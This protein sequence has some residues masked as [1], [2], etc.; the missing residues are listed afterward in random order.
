MHQI[1]FRDVVNGW[2]NA[3]PIGNGRMGAM[4]FYQ[5]HAL[6]IALN[7]YDCYYGILPAR[8]RNGS[9]DAEG[10][11][12]FADPARQLQT[13]EELCRLTEA[14]RE[15][16][17]A[18]AYGRTHYLR[19]LHPSA[20][21]G[22]PSYSGASYPMGGEI[23]LRLDERVNASDSCL[24][25]E[26][27]KGRI[28]FQ[29]GKEER[30]EAVL[31][32][33]AEADGV[34]IKLSQTVSGLWKTGALVIPS[35]VGLSYCRTETVQEDDYVRLKSFYQRE[36]SRQGEQVCQETA[37]YLPGAR[38]MGDGGLRFPE[39]FREMTA[40]ASMAAET[41]SAA[42]LPT[43]SETGSMASLPTVSET[44][45]MASLPTVAEA[46]AAASS[47]TASETGAAA[48]S[49][50]ASVPG[51][52]M[53]QSLKLVQEAGALEISH[54]RFWD[55]FWKSSVTLPDKFLETLWYLHVY[56]CGCSYGS[57]GKYP[58]Q[59]CGLSGLWDIRRPNMWGSMWYWD[60]NI[61]SA[62]WGIGACGHPELLKA[63]CDGYLEYEQDIR[64]FTRQV[65]GIEGWALDYPH[66]LY[67]CIQPWCACVL[68]EYFT[69]TGD[70]E[71]L[72]KKAYPVFRE[73]AAFFRY[74]AKE[75]ENKILHV[76]PD[77]SP[78]QG[79][80]TRDSVITIASIKKML[81]AG[82]QAA[83]LLGRPEEERV[84]LEELL[85]HLPAY[86]LTGDGRR[87][88]DSALAQEELFLRHPS[89]LMPIFPAGEITAP[90][91]CKDKNTV[92]ARRTAEE[93]LRYAAENTETGTFGA[94]WLA[95][96]AASLGMGNTALELLYE[97]GL[98]YT[99]HTN[100]LAYEE[101]ERFINY[102]HVTKPAHY[103]P[104]MC[105]ASGG[106][107][108]TVSRM[109]LGAGEVMEIFPALPSGGTTLAGE[110]VQY[111]ED[112][113][114][115][116]GKHICWE[117]AEFR[118]LMAPGGFRVSA[119]RKS[120]RTVFL[121]V[122]STMDAVLRLILPEGL[123][124]MP[125]GEQG[126]KLY[127]LSGSKSGQ[128]EERQEIK[129][130]LVKKELV[131]D[132]LINEKLICEKM[133]YEKR[134]YP[135]E[136]VV[137][138]TDIMPGIEDKGNEKGNRENSVEAEMER[139]SAQEMEGGNAARVSGG[140]QYGRV[141]SPEAASEV[142]VHEAARTARRI[143]LGEDRH[144]AFYKAVDSFV[145]PYGLADSRRYTMTPY[146]FDFGKTDTVKNYDNVYSPQIYRLQRCILYSAGPKRL[147][148]EEYKEGVGYGFGSAE[149][150]EAADR[151]LPDD[152]RRDFLEGSRSVQ[153]F[154]DLPAGK[155]DL[156]VVSGDEMEPSVTDVSLP[157]YG[158][159][160]KGERLAAGRYQCRV[161]PVMHEREG[162][163][164]LQLD[165]GAGEKWKLN[166]VFVNKEYAVL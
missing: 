6:H 150:I 145:C 70:L 20:Q 60:V 116:G 38:G 160:L 32:I 142:L 104:A 86:P 66:P 97:K 148:A 25:L 138:G 137:W 131:N 135:G 120:G 83:K 42:S 117:N 102:C 71:F 35:R 21:T 48:S 99:L 13:Y 5:D 19:T 46:G 106:I 53:G 55:A 12:T 11:K 22:R 79:P 139:R 149:G 153:F 51:K 64:R 29:A 166:A 18:E 126:G 31:Y 45:S 124:G 57:D 44:G 105:E 164:V 63:F 65:Y 16:A 128:E 27:E 98:D 30:A 17:G 1:V 152:M 129:E 39:R 108:V 115:A 15:R 101:S 24:R 111:L 133:I 100:G 107:T 123:S 26:I 140:L 41:G 94:G 127:R 56:L 144:T 87:W 89:V 67:N 4:V 49:T 92:E 156:L 43:V 157:Q 73:Q 119:V 74:L 134:M 112:K 82:I 68:W 161:L 96:A 52:A 62:F 77:I 122:E 114:T 125:Q 80:V 154:M 132:Q 146:I 110:E 95:A 81:Q 7:H 136:V 103:L 155:Y 143:F 34:V 14:A 75:D 2:H 28:C 91:S 3:L 90:G 163:L 40:S 58:E 93:T 36:G 59:A 10:G 113:E 23:V 9:G 130:R 50:M 69:Y 151:G 121:Q 47:T 78:E 162:L 33:P 109:L 118:G 76:E 8:D 37:L 158:T 61:Q 54:G 159:C 147:G 165:S 84:E 88:K 72:E 141:P 85:A